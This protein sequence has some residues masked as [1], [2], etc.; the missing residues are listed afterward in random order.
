MSV[1]PKKNEN[2]KKG[3]ITFVVIVLLVCPYFYQKIKFYPDL[4]RKTKGPVFIDDLRGLLFVKDEIL[5]E[6][7]N[8][9]A[10]KEM[11]RFYRTYSYDYKKA[12]KLDLK[13]A[14]NGDP[15]SQK[16]LCFDIYS[17][18]SENPY[19]IVIQ[20]DDV[21]YS[22]CVKSANQDNYYAQGLLCERNYMS[23]NYKEALNW[24]NAASKHPGQSL[25]KY[26]LGKMYEEGNG[27]EKNYKIAKAL[28]LRDLDGTYARQIVR[29]G[30]MYQE[31]KGVPKDLITAYMWYYSL[32][33]EYCD[34]IDKKN[35]QINQN[36]PDQLETAAI[37]LEQIEKELTPVQIETAKNQA[38]NMLENWE[39]LHQNLGRARDIRQYWFNKM[40]TDPYTKL[41][42]KYTAESINSR[43]NLIGENRIIDPQ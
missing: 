17:H 1:T 6:F 22:W 32:C 37:R 24:C 28:Y 9:H 20:P 5:S 27:V 16:N 26:M 39:E 4:H 29:L 34:H 38:I 15:E 14:E 11:V 7:G 25:A 18:N 21:A 19:N 13:L 43:Y 8:S 30:V 31:G 35:L 42:E 10:K 2:V 3:V 23:K 36:D 40:K 12:F 33:F 41:P